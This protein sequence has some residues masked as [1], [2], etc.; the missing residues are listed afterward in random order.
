MKGKPKTKLW[1]L[2]L[3]MK[4]K[5]GKCAKCGRNYY[6]TIDHIVP[7]TLLQQLNLI[8]EVYNWEDN[9]Q[10]ICGACNHLKSGMLDLSNE[11]TIPLLEEAV[12][13]AKLQ[14]NRQ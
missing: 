7:Q 3:E 8:D 14:T 10:I 12:K 11:K 9:F 1:E 4:H 13:R 6:L 5:L 2:Q